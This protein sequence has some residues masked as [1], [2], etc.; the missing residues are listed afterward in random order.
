MKKREFQRKATAELFKKLVEAFSKADENPTISVISKYNSSYVKIRK[1]YNLLSVTIKQTGELSFRL[2]DEVS[3]SGEDVIYYQY[4]EN[5]DHAAVAKKFA[6]DMG[7]LY[8]D[9]L[10]AGTF[11]GFT[12][13]RLSYLDKADEGL[14]GYEEYIR[15]ITL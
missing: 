15:E 2:M 1:S 7:R 6:A 12:N 4:D 9:L 14:K 10:K 5:D 8:K 13:I 11:H 3:D